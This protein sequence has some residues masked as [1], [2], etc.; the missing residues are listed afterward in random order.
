LAKDGRADDG[1]RGVSLDGPVSG[2]DVI[3]ALA[4][5]GPDDVD[6][7]LV[8]ARIDPQMRFADEEALERECPPE[9]IGL[10]EG[11]YR[12]LLAALFGEA[13]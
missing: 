4:R 2:A 5:F 12:A 1:G 9:R 7:G 13:E 3:A 10:S 6:P 8:E 11:A